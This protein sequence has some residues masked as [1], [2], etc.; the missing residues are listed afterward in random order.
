[1]PRRSLHGRPGQ[2]SE[3]STEEWDKV[4]AV[5]VNQAADWKYELKVRLEVSFETPKPDIRKYL[6]PAD[7]GVTGKRYQAEIIS[8]DPAQP[9][10]DDETATPRATVAPSK[11]Q[12]VHRSAQLIEASRKRG[13]EN[14]E[15]GRFEKAI[16]DR[17]QCHDKSCT[18]NKDKKSFCFVDYARKNN[19]IKPLDHARWAKAIEK[20]KDDNVS[21]ERPPLDLYVKWVGY[22]PVTQDTRRSEQYKERKEARAFASEGKDI[23]AQYNQMIENK[24]KMD[25]ARSMKELSNEHSSSNQQPPH[26]NNL[27]HGLNINLCRG[28]NGNNLNFNSLSKSLNNT[29]NPSAQAQLGKMMRML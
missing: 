18:N 4:D 8:S 21:L 7:R 14:V 15:A 5:I 2:I 29:S 20:A 27:L 25:I 16:I 26:G 13:Q 10:D 12:K 1:M 17:W 22:G 24:L 19:T 9:S 3:F 23:F 11:K 6:V 28:S